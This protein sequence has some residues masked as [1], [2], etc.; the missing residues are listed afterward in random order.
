M[1]D[2]T[3]SQ[4]EYEKL[5]QQL[6]QQAQMLQAMQA[7]QTQMNE[8]MRM[9]QEQMQMQQEQMIRQ[10]EQMQDM[11]EQMDVF[12]LHFSQMYN[13]QTIEESLEAMAELG[14]QEIG[15]A[16]CTVY[17]IDSLEDNRLFTAKDGEREYISFE[18]ESL[19]MQAIRN[20]ESLILE[21]EDGDT[22]LFAPLEDR[23]GEVIGLA[24]AQGKEGGFTRDDID[25][26]SLQNGKIGTAF[27]MGLENKSLHTQA[28][29]DK[30]THLTNRAGMEE[31][32]KTQ[33]LDRISYDEPVS[34]II[35]DIDHFKRFNDTYGHEVGDKVLKQVADILRDNMR[36]TPDTGVFRWGGEEMVIIVPTSEER[37]AEIA[38]RLR[39]AIEAQPLDIGNDLTE[40]I[41]VSG[42]V[43]QFHSEAALSITRD[44]VMDAFEETF[45]LADE[46]L[47]DAKEGGRNQVQRAYTV[48]DR[49][50]S[51]QATY[52][53]F[54]SV[55]DKCDNLMM[56][57]GIEVSDDK[58]AQYLAAYEQSAEGDSNPRHAE[59]HTKQA[60]LFATQSA[61]AEE[62]PNLR[63]NLAYVYHKGG[64]ADASL[65]LSPNGKEIEFTG[66]TR[67]EL[68]YD[69]AASDFLVTDTYFRDNQEG[70]ALTG[71]VIV[72]NDFLATLNTQLQE[73]GL[74]VGEKFAALIG[75]DSTTVQIE[76]A[77]DNTGNSMCLVFECA[78]LSEALV[79]NDT[80]MRD[81]MIQQIVKDTFPQMLNSNTLPQISE[82]DEFGRPQRSAAEIL[83]EY[84]VENL[85]G[86]DYRKFIKGEPEQEMALSEK[87]KYVTATKYS[88]TVVDETYWTAEALKQFAD[89]Y[90]GSFEISTVLDKVSW[91]SMSEVAQMLEDPHEVSELLCELM[92]KNVIDSSNPYDIELADEAGKM[93]EKIAHLQQ[94]QKEKLNERQYTDDECLEYAVNRSIFGNTRKQESEWIVPQPYIRLEAEHS[95]EVTTIPFAKDEGNGFVGVLRKDD[96]PVARLTLDKDNQT[97][98]IEFEKEDLSTA[99]IIRIANAY[100]EPFELIDVEVKYPDKWGELSFDGLDAY[101][102]IDKDGDIYR[103]T[104][105]EATER[106]ILDRAG[107]IED[108]GNMDIY[109]G[110]DASIHI[111]FVDD[112]Q[113]EIVVPMAFTET[114]SLKAALDAHE[115]EIEKNF[116][117]GEVAQKAIDELPA[118]AELPLVGS[119]CIE[120]MDNIIV[121]KDAD[122]DS[123]RDSLDDFNM[124]T[125]KFV[126]N[127]RDIAST[128][129]IHVSDVEKVLNDLRH[130]DTSVLVDES[131]PLPEL[132]VSEYDKR[133]RDS[134]DLCVEAEEIGKAVKE[135]EILT[136]RNPYNTQYDVPAIYK[137]FTEVSAGYQL[138]RN[139][140]P[141]AAAQERLIELLQHSIDD[142]NPK[143][144]ITSFAP[145]KAEEIL[146]MLQKFREHQIENAHGKHLKPHEQLQQALQDVMEY[147]F[148]QATFGEYTAHRIDTKHGVEI[149]VEK[150]DEFVA[151]LRVNLDDKGIAQ[152]AS[153]RLAPELDVSSATRTAV[154]QQMIDFTRQSNPKCEVAIREVPELSE[155]KGE[156]QALAQRIFNYSASYHHYGGGVAWDRENQKQMYSPQI[157]E[158]L[159]KPEFQAAVMADIYEFY[160]FKNPPL[161]DRAIDSV[162]IMEA[163][164]EYIIHT[165][166]A[167]LGHTLSEAETAKL[168]TD[169]FFEQETPFVKI[170]SYTAEDISRVGH[171]KTVFSKDGVDVA[172]STFRD[173]D[174]TG[175][176][177]V[178][179]KL[180]SEE[181][182]FF[183]SELEDRM[184][185]QGADK[186]RQK[187]LS[188]D[189]RG[190]AIE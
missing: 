83:D 153:A 173:H 4:E 139:P 112:S 35:L 123:S 60:Y 70:F 58:F 25:A 11:R 49:V 152:S 42:G 51:L 17:S 86:D 63:P 151:S 146:G 168:V 138:G 174:H 158:E 66:Q 124:V 111:D 131:T 186:V 40:Q 59:D 178:S 154:L 62:M 149:Q 54:E 41:T 1:A 119:R 22:M 14:K 5:M 24:T 87:D 65:T 171:H 160:K 122:F 55:K 183:K 53:S 135:A 32:I 28:T 23:N 80:L 75:S 3:L 172:A 110:E 126:V 38:D 48:P 127:D 94:M 109:I 78:E 72:T 34:T 39:K 33:A 67:D 156:A 13:A 175:T 145:D 117:V 137:A 157:A 133:I 8:L 31:F 44:T 37:A 132:V 2:V 141:Q 84:A 82:F 100:S 27:R 47:Y 71:N 106:E 147:P 43:A 26:F 45:K 121:V 74:D 12:S 108:T 92:Q 85:S 88:G 81:E 64:G 164:S 161:G 98:K 46:A 159:Q 125:L 99:E 20:K 185:E 10:Q 114:K 179:S 7:Q 187:K 167:E 155:L 79:I 129:D 56:T 95:Y 76:V 101:W 102:D 134:H 15:A 61:I 130:G 190:N 77:S 182:K 120:H 21:G 97:A 103:I 169:M 113:P 128:H 189:S 140:I 142:P 181:K 177:S 143:D 105:D 96:E 162:E 6:A 136:T 176:V 118:G 50:A 180:T 93:A 19:W 52:E 165:K 170:G 116:L 148:K 73:S 36:Q 188:K 144:C 184:K 107:I 30:L 163:L 91:A 29:T 104:L 9:Q 18:D 69:Y 115:T 68:V 16:Q 89:K 90:A 57:L 150:N 166:E